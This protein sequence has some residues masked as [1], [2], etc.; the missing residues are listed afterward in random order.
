[1]IMCILHLKAFIP[2]SLAR[3]LMQEDRF[4]NIFIKRRKP[5][6]MVVCR[7]MK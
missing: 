4:Q 2:L 3:S 1:M 5:S 7:S 6:C